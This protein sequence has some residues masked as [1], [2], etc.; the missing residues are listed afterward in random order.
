MAAIRLA[1]LVRGARARGATDVHFGGGDRPAL[2]IDGRLVVLDDPPVDEPAV[3]A[4]LAAVLSAGQIAHLD[5]EGTADGAAARAADGAP[6]RVHAYRHGGGVRVAIRLLAQ[7]VPTLEQL[8]L[9]AVVAT[10]AQRPAGLVL[11]TG[12]TGSGKTTALAALIDRINRGSER[13]VVTVEDPVEYVHVPARS[14][15]THCEIG[16]DVR[17]YA[18]ALRG[19]LRADPDVILIGEMRD[20]ATFAAALTAAETGHLV[21]ATLH[22]NDAAQT[23]DRIVDAFPADAHAQV[24]SQLASVLAGI[25]A[26][27]LVPR[28]DGAGRRTAAEILVGTDA[29]RALIREGKTHQLRNT[30]VTGRAAG[31][32]TLETHLSDLVVRGEVTLADAQAATNRPGDVRA[33]ERTAS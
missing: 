10:F 13:N 29:V 28:H 18:E 17:D 9:P 5:A 27:R 23:V 12:P 11:F 31:M 32:Q 2:R 3:R 7:Q 6:Y 22:T 20:R 25:V 24:R 21:F 30:I 33:F 26:L 14:F 8:G 4:F 16:R 15:V 1:E 19:L